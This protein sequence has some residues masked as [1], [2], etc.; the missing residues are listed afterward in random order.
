MIK[1]FEEFVSTVY[2][3][4]IN[5]AFQSSKLREL[6]KQHG[7][8]KYK[9]SDKL[10]FDLRDNDIIG[11]FY[12]SDDYNEYYKKLSLSDKKEI[13]TIYLKDDTYVVVGNYDDVKKRHSERHKHN[14]GSRYE[15]KFIKNMIIQKLKSMESEI[16]EIFGKFIYSGEIEEFVDDEFIASCCYEF[17]GYYSFSSIQTQDLEIEEIEQYKHFSDFFINLEKI[18]KSDEIFGKIT[19]ECWESDGDIKCK[20]GSF[21]LFINYNGYEYEISNEDIGITEKTHKDL[22]NKTTIVGDTSNLSSDWEY[23]YCPPRPH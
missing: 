2:G 11:V 16:V 14:S 1:N 5:E 19:Y 23:D 12:N 13:E 6:I 10:L 18:I 3:S 8:L 21:L 7:G 22:F 20:L 15:D 4:T 17:D 9:Y